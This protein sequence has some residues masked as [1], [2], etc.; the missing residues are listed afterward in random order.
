MRR[1]TKRRS[2]RLRLQLPPQQ[3]ALEEPSAAAGK[4]RESKARKRVYRGSQLR[5]V[6]QRINPNKQINRHAT[7][8]GRQP[9]QQHRL[10]QRTCKIREYCSAAVLLPLLIERCRSSAMDCACLSVIPRQAL[11]INALV[12]GCASFGSLRSAK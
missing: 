9:P 7:T 2:P 3:L 8:N 11:R 10:T 4:R 1:R 12:C 5:L 6:A